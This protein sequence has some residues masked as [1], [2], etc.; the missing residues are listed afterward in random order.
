MVT[1]IGCDA[2]IDQPV[3]VVLREFQS[4]FIG[5]INP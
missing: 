1:L 3:S 5:M 4:A 2:K